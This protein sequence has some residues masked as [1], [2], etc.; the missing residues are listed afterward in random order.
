MEYDIGDKVLLRVTFRDTD[1]DL[2]TP[3]TTT[4]RIMDPSGNVT[5]VNNAS[6]STGGTGIKEYEHTVDEAGEWWYRF[7][8]SGNIVAAEEATFRVRA[9]QVPDA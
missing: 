4:L 6:I 7:N 2:T 5:V 8:G 1:G 9:Q 3:T